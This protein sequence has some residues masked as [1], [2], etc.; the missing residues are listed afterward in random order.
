[1]Y[2]IISP[3]AS[4]WVSIIVAAYTIMSQVI[5]ISNFRVLFLKFLLYGSLKILNLFDS[6]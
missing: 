6:D 1:M 5:S 2:C 4:Q 3:N